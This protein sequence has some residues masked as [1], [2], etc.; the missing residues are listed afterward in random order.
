MQECGS[1]E[2]QQPVAYVDLRA[3]SLSR[4]A[5]KVSLTYAAASFELKLVQLHP[6]FVHLTGLLVKGP[7][8]TFARK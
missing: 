8:G 6:L 5:G 4:F 2:A 7:N 1:L 3:V